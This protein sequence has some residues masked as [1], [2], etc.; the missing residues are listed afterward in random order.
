[1][2]IVCDGLTAPTEDPELSE[3][4]LPY[5]SSEVAEKTVSC[6]ILRVMLLR[7][8]SFLSRFPQKKHIHAYG[9]HVVMQR[10]DVKDYAKK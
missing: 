7:L 5:Y 2:S 3:N 9:A 8:I 1:M 10:K 4:R 6:L